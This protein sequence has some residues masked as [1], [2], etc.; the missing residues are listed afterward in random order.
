MLALSIGSLVPLV[1]AIVG[2]IR[3]QSI[4]AVKALV[5]ACLLAVYGLSS[6]WV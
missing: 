4:I 6:L 2:L 3:S 5:G 1:P